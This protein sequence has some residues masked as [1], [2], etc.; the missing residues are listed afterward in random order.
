MSALQG[1]AL[2]D[3]I[4]RKTTGYQARSMFGKMTQALH[5]AYQTLA[6]YQST[7]SIAV[8][9]PTLAAVKFAITG[10]AI[11]AARQYLDSTNT[12]LA[13]YYAAMPE[14][15]AVLTDLQYQ[16]LQ[17]AVSGASVAVNQ[18]DQM[19]STPWSSELAS[20]LAAAAGTITAQIATT[21]AKV[22]GSA[23]GSF[24]GK[25][26]WLLLLGAG[27]VSAYFLIQR[28]IQRRVVKRILP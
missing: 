15:N 19:F 18:V 10:D 22:A 2:A 17:T 9:M 14:S 3:I 28:R 8:I 12:M 20:D 25:T 5:Q 6:E 11:T 1:R 23:V 4:P 26:W 21:A 7:G 27:G 24:V 16:Q 13:K